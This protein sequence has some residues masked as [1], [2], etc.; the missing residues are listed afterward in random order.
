MRKKTLTT[1]VIIH[2]N[3]DGNIKYIQSPYYDKK[4]NNPV[5]G[6]INR[7]LGYLIKKIIK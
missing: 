4:E 1:G 6:S 5:R 7:Y 2:Y 3:S